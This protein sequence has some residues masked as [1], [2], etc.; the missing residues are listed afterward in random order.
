MHRPRQV[1]YTLAT[2]RIDKKHRLRGALDLLTL[3]EYC[4]YTLSTGQ[5]RA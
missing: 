4:F 2:W 3:G 1:P 5:V